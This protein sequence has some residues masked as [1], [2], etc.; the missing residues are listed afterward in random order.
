MASRLKISI[1]FI[2]FVL[3]C[4][5]GYVFFANP[6]QSFS[7]WGD[8]SAIFSNITNGNSSER[9][10]I[11]IMGDRGAGSNDGPYLTD[12]IMVFSYLP[13]T[14]QASLISLPRDLYVNI[15]GFGKNKI[16]AAYEFGQ[17]YQTDQG[18]ALATRVVEKVTGLDISFSAVVEEAA[19]KKLVDYIGGVDV[20]RDTSFKTSDVYP[21][22]NLPVGCT[23]LNGSQVI[24]YTISRKSDSDF[25]RAARQQQVLTLLKQ[26]L[27][28][29]QITSSP[30]KLLSIYKLISANIHTDLS[31][32]QVS[33]LLKMVE[34]IDFNSI[35]TYVFS[36]SKVDNFLYSTIV[37]GMYVL[38]PTAGEGNYTQI[39]YKCAHI[40]DSATGYGYSM[41]STT[42]KT[43]TSVD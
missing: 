17:V 11:L 42:K 22:L 12:A 34:N 31:L 13:N 8:S 7:L 27:E 9:I 25:E 10:N 23:H 24:S 29:M 6:G 28:D 43:S 20:C 14:K 3:V 37:N 26:K 41:A 2:G 32:T 40:F 36:D 15:P 35:K 16:N 21:V 18:L 39:Q 4:L 19:L 38:L 1:L 33:S 5:V 30:T